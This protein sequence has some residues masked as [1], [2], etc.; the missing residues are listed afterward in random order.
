MKVVHPQ[1]SIMFLTFEENLNS[2]SSVMKRAT[3][4]TLARHASPNVRLHLKLIIVPM[5]PNLSINSN[6][7]SVSYHKHLSVVG[8]IFENSPCFHAIYFAYPT[9]ARR[10]QGSFARQPNNWNRF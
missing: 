9:S 8:D 7:A 1:N 3:K 2:L 5:Y 4:T 10:L 6:V